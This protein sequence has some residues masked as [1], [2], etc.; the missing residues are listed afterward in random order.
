MKK[1]VSIIPDDTIAQRILFIRRQ[2]VI[3]DADVAFLYGVSTKRL[4]EQV[5]RNLDRF[6]EDFV[7]QLTE[8]EKQEVVANCDHRK[9]LKF[10]QY[11][12]SAFTEYGVLMAANV[13]NRLKAIHD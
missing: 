6:P 2:K 11:R 7:I 1:D 3:I 9:K 8:E 12:P 10:L 13:L 5:C 4:K